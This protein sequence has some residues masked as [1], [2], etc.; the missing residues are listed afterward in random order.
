M[1]YVDCNNHQLLADFF[2]HHG[3]EAV[4]LYVAMDNNNA[5]RKSFKI[6]YDLPS[7]S[8]LKDPPPEKRYYDSNLLIPD[9]FGVV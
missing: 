2:G 9:S 1:E 5:K 3:F 7:L 6:G 4:Q 8:W